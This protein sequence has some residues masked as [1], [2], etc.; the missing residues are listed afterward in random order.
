MTHKGHKASYFETRD[1]RVLFI[2]APPVVTTRSE[3]ERERETEREREEK[4]ERK[5]PLPP[6]SLHHLAHM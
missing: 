5:K 1:Y 6:A 4:E 2:I 3:R